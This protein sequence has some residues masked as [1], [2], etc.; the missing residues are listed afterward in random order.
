MD[1]LTKRTI[2]K[3][4]ASSFYT[5]KVKG[6]VSSTNTVLKRS[7]S[8]LDTGYVLCARKQT[9]G[10]GR[11]DRRFV[12]PKDRGV[13]FS[14][15]MRPNNE[16][17]AKMLTV[18]AAV[19]VSRA[20]EELTGKDA[21]IKWVNDVYFDDKKC[22]GIL[23]EAQFGSDGKLKHAIVGIGV[24][25]AVPR[26]GFDKEIE[27]VASAINLKGKNAKGEL[28][29]KILNN[30]EHLSTNFDKKTIVDEYIKRS[31]IIGKQVE[32]CKQE[33]DATPA[34]VE[35]VDENCNLI[36]KYL[37]GTTESLCAG[38]VRIKL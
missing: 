26:G 4:L 2:E 37:D 28:V 12:S 8:T 23:T 11:F 18:I 27:G 30:F 32:V 34:L 22:A 14:I 25:V 36:V 9:A 24:N 13:Y 1:K 5:I 31:F 15:L 19:S 38:E 29:G 10:R 21:P 6:C 3:C 17:L 7:A 20:V 33:C 35:S 16:E